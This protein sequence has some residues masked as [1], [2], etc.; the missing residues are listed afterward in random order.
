MFKEDYLCRSGSS[1]RQPLLRPA[2]ATL[3]SERRR[4]R[5]AR[6]AGARAPAAPPPAAAPA[7]APH[8][9]PHPAPPADSDTAPLL[10]QDTHSINNEMRGEIGEMLLLL[11]LTLSCMQEKI[12]KHATEMKH[13]LPSI[14]PLK[15]V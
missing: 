14:K 5:R 9:A 6:S 15:N 13:L 2:V 12:K 10:P 8:P 7:P 3:T 4:R 1:E 11:L